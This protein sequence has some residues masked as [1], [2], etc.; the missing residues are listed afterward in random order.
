MN[1]MTHETK[2][3][4]NRDW[5]RAL[6][7]PIWLVAMVG[8]L[9]AAACAEA[10][11]DESSTQALCPQA[12]TSLT[13]INGTGKRIRDV[14]IL[15]VDGLTTPYAVSDP[16][17]GI[18]VGGEV[19]FRAC[20]NAT[21][22]MIITLEDG[23]TDRSDLPTLFPDTNRLTLQP[24]PLEP[25]PVGPKPPAPKTINGDQGPTMQSER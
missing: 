8:L 21:Q 16:L 15:S 9:Q 2:S 4:T 13:L 1:Y 22:A 3:P 17:L 18:P 25:A 20:A 6:G 10:T 24:K 5:T 19:T 14:Q 11:E 12:D 23:S 7:R